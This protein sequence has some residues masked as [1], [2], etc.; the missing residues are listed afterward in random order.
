M[1]NRNILG[2][3]FC[4]FIVVLF[5]HSMHFGAPC[6]AN[7]PVRKSVVDY[8]YL[9]PDF[10]F[11]SHRSKA[12]RKAVLFHDRKVYPH[13]SVV[14][15][16]ADIKNDYVRVNL[17]SLGTLEIAVFRYK[18]R[19]LIAVRRYYE[20]CTVWFLRYQNSRWVNVTKQIMPVSLNNK[21]DYTLPR[22]GTTI[23]VRRD[24]WPS[25]KRGRKLYDL[26]WQKGRFHVRQ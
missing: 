8:Y 14:K 24:A 15:S 21:Y 9:L 5:L 7:A 20:G 1:K 2:W 25:E 23:E 19:D 10:Y 18:G 11:E 17:D 16:T 22:Y 6:S 26:V 12:E 13:G 4:V 3:K